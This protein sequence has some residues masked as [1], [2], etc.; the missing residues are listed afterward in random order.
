MGM[1]LC[2]TEETLISL[3]KHGF[4]RGGK[5]G[6]SIGNPVGNG[7]GVLYTG[8]TAKVSANGL[9][10]NG[11]EPKEHPKSQHGAGNSWESLGILLAEG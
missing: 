6:N 9:K 7:G 3:G 2:S 5:L 1:P 10:I 11:Q 8:S 4:G